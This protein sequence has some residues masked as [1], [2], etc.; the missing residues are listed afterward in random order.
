LPP[1]ERVLNFAIITKESNE[2][3]AALHNRMPAILAPEG[4]AGMAGRGSG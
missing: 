3:C 4:M 2:L 1:G